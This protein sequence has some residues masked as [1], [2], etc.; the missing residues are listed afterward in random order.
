MTQEVKRSG[1]DRPS[2]SEEVAAQVA[3]GG[4]AVADRIVIDLR[5]GEPIV[6]SLVFTP[7]AGGLL[8]AP[9]WA[10]TAKRALDIVGASIALIVLLPLMLLTA[11]AVALTSPGPVLFVQERVGRGGRPFRMLKFRSMIQDAEAQRDA[12]LTLN[13]HASGPIFK[14]RDD[15]R[16]TPVG[17]LMRLLSIDELPQFLNVLGGSMSLVGPRPPLP[18]EV[19]TYDDWEAQRLLV[20]PGI[21]CLWQ[22]SGRSELDFATW[23]KLD[24]DYIETWSLWMDLKVLAR[25]IPAVLSRRGAC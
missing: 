1:Y 6:D 21:T 24:L 10:R 11:L 17:R 2:F 20:T 15:P 16:I 14:I 4:D 9:A 23:V 18:V 13:E 5:S 22:V 19:R 25:T 12:L 8:A 3:F 7:V